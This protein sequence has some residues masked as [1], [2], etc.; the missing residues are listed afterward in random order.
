[1]R[2]R[3]VKAFKVK[4]LVVTGEISGRG[5]YSFTDLIYFWNVDPRL[6]RK[7]ESWDEIEKTDLIVLRPDIE[8]EW[9]LSK[10]KPRQKKSLR[11]GPKG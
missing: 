5:Y 4:Y 9:D 2:V 8:N 6:C 3:R 7:A 10:L 11:I 1:M